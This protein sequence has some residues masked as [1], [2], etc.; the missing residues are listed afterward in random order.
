MPMFLLP[1]LTFVEN[2][3]KEDQRLGMRLTR[4][5]IEPLLYLDTYSF[6]FGM[7]AY[8]IRSLYVLP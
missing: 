2:L 7:R 6:N 5:F 3:S 8:A 1:G 4:D